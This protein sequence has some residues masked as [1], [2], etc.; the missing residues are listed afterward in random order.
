MVHYWCAYRDKGVCTTHHICIHVHT[1]R[2]SCTPFFLQC[3][4]ELA[5]CN[6][7]MRTRRGGII[8][9]EYQELLHGNGPIRLLDSV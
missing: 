7:Q 5:S 6:L 4:D 3:T 9:V 2:V 8:G 1:T